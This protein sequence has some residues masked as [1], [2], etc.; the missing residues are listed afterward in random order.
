MKPTRRTRLCLETLESRLAPAALTFIDVD[1]DKVS[2]TSSAGDISKK[3]TFEN[4][5]L[6]KQLQSLDLTDASFQGAN[7]ST[8]V[9]RVAT[10]DGLV[11]IGRINAV[12]RDLG[13]VTIGGDLGAIDCGDASNPASACRG[14]SVRSMGRYLLLTGAPD[15]QSDLNGNLEKLSV[16][17][18]VNGAFI[19]VANGNIGSIFIGGSLIGAGA[20]DSGN[21][22]ALDGGIGAVTIQGDIVGGA[23][24][25]SGAV[26]CKLNLGNLRVGGSVLGGPGFT[27]GVIFS[28]TGSVGVVTIGGSIVG[29]S[30]IFTGRVFGKTKIAS[31][32]LGGSL[33]GSALDNS[34]RIHSDGDI[35][36]VKVKGDLVGGKGTH[37]GEITAASGLTGVSIGGSVIGGSGVFSGSISGKN[38]GQIKVGH[39]LLGGPTVH[40]GEIVA[41]GNLAGV[42]I[43]GSLIGNSQLSGWIN[44]RG[45]DIGPVVIGGDVRGG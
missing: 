19:A 26:A 4:F 17:L 6:G 30:S 1:G 12:G 35:G 42:T 9:A 8:S 33:I 15:L 7:I 34:G 44:A 28:S 43:G 25:T 37:S 2:I 40:S 24:Q 21:I 13:K 16:N 23:G 3:A 5:G 36:L 10:G 39:D 29:G 31:V 20:Q 14:L 18:D 11:N 41:A 22:T 45:G 32:T 27:S 38:L